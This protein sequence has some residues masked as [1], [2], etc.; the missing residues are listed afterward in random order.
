MLK[1]WRLVIWGIGGRETLA[2]VYPLSDTRRH[3]TRPEA[4]EACWCQPSVEQVNPHK[5]LIW[6]R[7]ADGRELVEQHGVN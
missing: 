4:T 1:G 2:V 7:A 3:V 6:H 5:K